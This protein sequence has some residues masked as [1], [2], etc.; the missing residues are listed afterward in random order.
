MPTLIAALIDVLFWF[1]Y[2]VLRMCR[3]LLCL[4]SPTIVLPWGGR[5]R[6]RRVD[7][8]ISRHSWFRSAYHADTHSTGRRCWI[9]EIVNALSTIEIYEMVEGQQPL[10]APCSRCL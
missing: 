7:R 2:E 4:A 10:K 6:G 9:V 8:C 3:Q 5:A 1:L